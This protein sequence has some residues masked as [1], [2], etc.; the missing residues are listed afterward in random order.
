MLS[1]IQIYPSF[2]QILPKNILP[3]AP[4][5]SQKMSEDTRTGSANTVS[6]MQAVAV[7]LISVIRRRPNPNKDGY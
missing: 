4:S 2:F 5:E 6:N 3:E 7:K 1:G